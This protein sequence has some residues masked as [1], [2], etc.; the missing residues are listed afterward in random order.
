[1]PLRKAKKVTYEIKL[2]KAKAPLKN[3]DKVGT[4][5]LKEN[6]KQTRTVE[7]TIKEKIEKAGGKV[8]LV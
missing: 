8:E 7:L 6:G 3:G 1:M 5:I 2:D 4:L